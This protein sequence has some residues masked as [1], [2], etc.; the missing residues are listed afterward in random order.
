MYSEMCS[1]IVTLLD[2]RSGLRAWGP[3]HIAE[4]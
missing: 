3:Y 4:D 1:E 2:A